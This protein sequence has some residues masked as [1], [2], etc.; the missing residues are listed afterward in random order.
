MVRL[1][2]WVHDFPNPEPGRASRLLFRYYSVGSML[3]MGFAVAYYITDNS[4]KSANQWY[5]RPDFKPFAAMV[6]EPVR[7]LTKETML[8][9]QYVPQRE[10]EGKRSPIYRWFMGRDA[11]YTIKENPY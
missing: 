6:D 9:G 5:T 1:N 3:L 10:K 7:N 4:Q 2:R 8:E 11:D